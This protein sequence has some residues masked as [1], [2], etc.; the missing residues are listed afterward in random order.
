MTEE[1]IKA[2]E[3][4]EK[5]GYKVEF[6]SFLGAILTSPDRKE[7]PRPVIYL[8]TRC[9][10]FVLHTVSSSWTMAEGRVMQEDLNHCMAVLEALAEVAPGLVW[11][12][13]DCQ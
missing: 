6:D 13:S 9:G 8:D 1:Q 2:K 10:R 12:S 4:L 7:K 5:F 3:V 11:G